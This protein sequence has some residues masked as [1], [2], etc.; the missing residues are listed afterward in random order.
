MSDKKLDAIKAQIKTELD[1]M[2]LKEFGDDSRLIGL[3]DSEKITAVIDDFK[4]CVKRK[5][6]HGKKFY[7]PENKDR[8][9]FEFEG[10][11]VTT[12]HYVYNL[13]RLLHDDSRLCKEYRA[14]CNPKKR[15]LPAYDD[16]FFRMV[17]E[18]LKDE[19][20]ESLQ[21]LN[22]LNPGALVVVEN[23]NSKSAQ[24][25]RIFLSVKKS[26]KFYYWANSYHGNYELFNNVSVP[27]AKIILDDFFDSKLCSSKEDIDAF[28]EICNQKPEIESI[29]AMEKPKKQAIKRPLHKKYSGLYGSI[30]YILKH[31]A[32]K[33]A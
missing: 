9:T 28:I 7:T 20:Y 31:N 8:I 14:F 27:F 4:E 15:A 18:Y 1:S 17:I 21:S 33:R 5:N 32:K 24:F 16:S 11:K 19:D 2:I 13:F 12:Y 22:E 6:Q 25:G 30:N 23:K 26:G 3:N 29:L 10:F